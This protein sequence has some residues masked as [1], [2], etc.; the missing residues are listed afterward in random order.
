MRAVPRLPDDEVN[1]SK[2]HPLGEAAWLTV[3]V[4]LA[5]ALVYSAFAWS[6]EIVASWIPLDVELALFE[7][8]S[9]Q[10]LW[11]E[12]PD[13]ESEVGQLSALLARLAEHGPDSPYDHH[14]N[15]WTEDAPNAFALPGGT[16]VV[17]TGLLKVMETE[18]ELAFVLAHELGHFHN[19]DHLVMLGRQALFGLFLAGLG[20]GELPSNAVVET[21]G[22]LVSS[23]YSRDQERAA[24]HYALQLMQA[25]YGHVAGATSSLA[26]LTAGDLTDLIGGYIGSHPGPSERIGEVLR[27]ASS[28]GLTLTGQELAVSWPR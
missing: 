21:S 19:R 13:P 1:V 9:E 6:A 14:V 27:I 3:G 26:R 22:N 5:A 4:G 16:I 10:L 23:A 8:L 12:N 15:L 28:E 11:D 2:R 18:N 25:E 20:L 24:D 17:T 7:T